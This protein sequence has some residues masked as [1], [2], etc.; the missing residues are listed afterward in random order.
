MNKLADITMMKRVHARPLNNFSVQLLSQFKKAHQN[1]YKHAWEFSPEEKYRFT[2]IVAPRQWNYT[3]GNMQSKSGDSRVNLGNPKAPMM[4]WVREER[5]GH[6]H[7]H[8]HTHTHL[9][10]EMSVGDNVFQ[11][12]G[13][14]SVLG[15]EDES[16]N[17][18]V[19]TR[20]LSCPLTFEPEDK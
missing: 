15:T 20:N 1:Y 8:T 6:T 13:R 2:N 9:C 14:S 11:N 5:E 18:Y 12:L 17:E 19:C 10:S 4:L 7:T 3:I 16:G